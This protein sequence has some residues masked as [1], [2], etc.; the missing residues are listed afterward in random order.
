MHS[1]STCISMPL[2]P[3]HTHACGAAVHSRVLG[4]SRGTRV[5]AVEQGVRLFFLVP[6]FHSVLRARLT[7][8]APFLFLFLLFPLFCFLQL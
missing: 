5:L 8:M 6:R 2:E 7:I 4:N 3:E 1:P